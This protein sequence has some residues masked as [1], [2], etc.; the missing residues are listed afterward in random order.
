M[1][2]RDKFLALRLTHV[3]TG[4]VATLLTV[5]IVFGLVAY[6]AISGA[7]NRVQGM[8]QHDQVMLISALEMELSMRGMA[9]TTLEF[10]ASPEPAMREK[11]LKDSADFNR[12]MNRYR[13]TAQGDLKQ[14]GYAEKGAALIQAV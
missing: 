10:L 9:I 11:I 1:K 5:V 3:L 4:G 7:R 14:T 6:L 8:A 2:L 12:H 13:G